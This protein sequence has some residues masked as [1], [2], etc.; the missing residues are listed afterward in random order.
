MSPYSQDPLE[1]AERHPDRAIRHSSA[2]A[3][4][5]RARAV[6]NG[7]TIETGEGEWRVYELECGQYDRR[8]GPSLIFESDGVL[9][10]VRDYPPD[11]R[12]LSDAELMQVSW[13]R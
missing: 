13:H 2:V 12:E 4:S 5:G 1:P 8:A 7:R 3:E 11:W 9:R 10:R 6:A